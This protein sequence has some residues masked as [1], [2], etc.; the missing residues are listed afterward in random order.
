MPEFLSQ[1][2]GM[3]AA[4]AWAG[5]GGLLAM[6]FVTLLTDRV[7]F[8]PSWDSPLRTFLGTLVGALG[9]VLNQTQDGGNPVATTI[10]V[11]AT[12][13]PTLLAEL[14]ALRGNPAP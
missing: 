13:L 10:S 9:L 6:T 4:H 14:A 7:H 3:I 11:V 5:V 1:L 12:T 8:L 2:A